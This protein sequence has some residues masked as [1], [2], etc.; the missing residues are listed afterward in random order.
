MFSFLFRSDSCST[1]VDGNQNNETLSNLDEE[2]KNIIGESSDDQNIVGKSS[3]DR[4]SFESNCVKKRLQNC[5]NHNLSSSNLLINESIDSINLK[6][7]DTN[8]NVDNSYQDKNGKNEI[9]YENIKSSFSSPHS[10]LQKL[11]LNIPA[12]PPRNRSSFPPTR[13]QNVETHL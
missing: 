1:I 7:P 3:D 12:L 6:L 2:N 13:T 5:E 10:M 9:L 8:L 4:N 11:N